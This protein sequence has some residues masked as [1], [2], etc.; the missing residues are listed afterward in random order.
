[1]PSDFKAEPRY[2]N[3]EAWNIVVRQAIQ[4]WRECECGCGRPAASG[5][6]FVSRRNGDDVAQNC[7]VLAGSGT[8]FCH[9]AVEGNIVV[10]DG[11]RLTPSIVRG[12]LR[13]RVEEVRLDVKAYALETMGQ[14]WLD[15]VYP[16]PKGTRCI[17]S[18]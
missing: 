3:R 2:R 5:H 11:E 18:N 14:A 6:H 15:R 8:T 17:R 13:L 1:M 4:R 16:L 9:G 7:L 10:V 12:L